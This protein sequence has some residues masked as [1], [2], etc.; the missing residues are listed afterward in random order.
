MTVVRKFLFD[1][2]FK[3]ETPLI[4]KTEDV[5]EDVEPEVIEPVFKGYNLEISYDAGFDDGKEEGIREA[6]S[7]VQQQTSETL[8]TIMKNLS[9]IYGIQEKANVVEARNA[10]AAALAV[11]RKALPALGERNA[12][13]EIE[14]M[15]EMILKKVIDEPQVTVRVNDKLHDQILEHVEALVKSGNFKGKLILQPDSALPISDCKIDWG[16]GGAERNMEVLWQ[17]IDAIIERNFN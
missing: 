16:S 4:E 10:M 17:E 5:V 8:K 9:D 14:R 2:D 1:V 6:S 12:L 13:G 15:I 7:A 11:A 3:E